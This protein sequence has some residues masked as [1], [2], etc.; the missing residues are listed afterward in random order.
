MDHYKPHT[1]AA[2]EGY[3]TRVQL[4]TGSSLILITCTV[5]YAKEKAHQSCLTYVSASG[6]IW[7][8]L[9]WPVDMKF[10]ALPKEVGGDGFRLAGKGSMEGEEY[11]LQPSTKGSVV[12][13]KSSDVDCT[14]ESGDPTPWS[15]N[16]WASSPESWLLYLPIPL[17]WHV[18]SLASPCSVTLKLPDSIASNN[19]DPAD[20][21]GFANGGKIQGIAHQEKNWALS[22]PSAHIWLQARSGDDAGKPRGITCAGGRIMGMDAF[23]LGYRNAEKG[24]ELDF[25]PPW[26]LKVF[27]LIGPGLSTD[28]DWENRKFE[29]VARGFLW[30]LVIKA[31]GPKGSFY[32]LVSPYA[33]GHKEN[34]LAQTLQATV[35]VEVWRKRG[36]AT[37][38]MGNVQA[39]LFGEWELVCLDEFEKGALEFG[40]DYYPYKG[41]DKKWH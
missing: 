34:W 9:C 20:R 14:I 1:L 22:F 29:L 31:V 36:A 5:P 6:K 39:A 35:K 2:F 15:L 23:L 4:K 28:I 24:I 27:G 38:W 11:V 3:Y 17:H 18:Y 7:Q 21:A 16:T 12:R 10:E 32:P 8:Q 25:R 13:H 37:G 30:K 40:G 33:T 26:A 19:F 41:T